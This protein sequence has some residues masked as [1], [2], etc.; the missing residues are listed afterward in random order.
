[1]DI[2]FDIAPIIASILGM[3]AAIITQYVAIKKRGTQK[4]LDEKKDISYYVNNLNNKMDEAKKIQ[5]I[6]DDKIN[7]Q[8]ETAKKLSQKN[9]DLKNEVESLSEL[10]KLS[11]K[12]IEGLGFV[13]GKEMKEFGNRTR[14]E[15]IAIAFFF[16]SL[17]VFISLSIPLLHNLI[18]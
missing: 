7:T 8:L 9:E 6:I 17:G 4:K 14:K 15:N 10:K 13:L 16:F 12:Q 18:F 11:E 3:V 1:M 2:L 5:I